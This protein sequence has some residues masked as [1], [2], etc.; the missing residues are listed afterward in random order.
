MWRVISVLRTVFD[1]YYILV[2]IRVVLSWVPHNPQA[3][4][5]NF[6]YTITD[7]IIAPIRRLMRRY[8]GNYPIGIDFSPLI[9]IVLLQLVEAIIIK[10]LLS[11]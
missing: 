2:I 10:I 7:F 5:F 11:L 3:P 4:I 9:A 6:I 8:I 1:V